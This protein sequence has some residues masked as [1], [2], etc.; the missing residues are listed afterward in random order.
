MARLNRERHRVHF[1]DESPTG[2]R[3]ELAGTGPGKPQLRGASGQS[4]FFHDP[5]QEI[6]GSP[7]LLSFMPLVA[8]PQDPILPSGLDDCLD[9]CG[10]NVHTDHERT[11]RHAHS[12]SVKRHATRPL[13][14]YLPR[15]PGPA[16]DR[17]DAASR[18]VRPYS[19]E[20]AAESRRSSPGFS[21]VRR[22]LAGAHLPAPSARG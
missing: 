15:P 6:E 12:S 7:A 3:S 14:L 18:G 11:K 4:Y 22:G 10:A 2:S 8:L 1:L 5:V 20:P 19:R 16:R 9:G 17:M 21:A 13:L